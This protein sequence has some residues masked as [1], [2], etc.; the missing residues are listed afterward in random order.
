MNKRIL[1]LLSPLLVAGCAL[2]LPVQIAS[3]A[4][5]GI[6]YLATRKS[7]AE[8]G[9]SIVTKKDCEVLRGLRGDGLCVDDVVSDT[10]IAAFDENPADSASLMVATMNAGKAAGFKDPFAA[11]VEEDDGSFSVAALLDID[12]P[13]MVVA[14]IRDPGTLPTDAAPRANAFVSADSSVATFANTVD[15]GDLEIF[16]TASMPESEAT[17]SPSF[18]DPGR[19]VSA[20][21]VARADVVEL[22]RTDPALTTDDKTTLLADFSTAAG[23]TDE[24]ESGENALAQDSMKPVVSKESP[25]AVTPSYQSAESKSESARRSAAAAQ[26]QK[27]HGATVWV[28]TKDGLY[29]VLGSFGYLDNARRAARVFSSLGPSVVSAKVN[30][31]KMYR[32]VVG[33][34]DDTNK[35]F[36]KRLLIDAGIADSWS[37]SLDSTTWTLVKRTQ[38]A[39]DEVASRPT[40]HNFAK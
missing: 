27:V 6:S 39:T 17:E 35:E 12:V 2:P 31:R 40:R 3:W 34:F 28:P 18:D 4:I 37:I 5:D 24:D 20:F 25:I 33:P 11:L 15:I 38:G 23:T 30:D 29:Y 32:V 13:K 36:G 8:H 7:V 21:V 10:A 26:S 14:L 16:T 1:I 9:L 22:D 19:Q